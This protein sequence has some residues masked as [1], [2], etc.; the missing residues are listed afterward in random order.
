MKDTLYIAYK[1][2]VFHKLKTSILVACI[3]IILF[4]PIA[5]N[6]LLKESEKQFLS[7]A[8][9][10]PLLLGAKGSSLDLC[11]NSLYFDDEIPEFITLKA[12]EEVDQTGFANAI[13][14]YTRF[15]ARDFPVIG[16]TLDYFS[17]REL[18]L[19]N[20]R[21]FAMLGECVIGSKVAEE[22]G[23]SVGQHL[24][25]AS[26]S[27]FDL[28]G[29]YPLKMKIVGVLTPSYSPDDL[30]VFV[31]LKTC[32][33][34]Q[35]L[36]HGHQD[37]SKL[38]DPTLVYKQ[39]DSVVSATAKLI[40]YNEINEDNI[41]SFHFHGSLDAYPIT[42]LVIFPE[43]A[44]SG[45]LLQGRYVAD[46]SGFQLIKPTL[47][48]DGLLQNIFKISKVI[49]GVIIIVS[50]ATI[51]AMFLIFSLS[52]RLRAKEVETTFKLGCQKGTM[53][54]F[55]LA[56]VVI[57]SGLSIFVC[58]ILYSVFNLYQNDLIRLLYF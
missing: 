22:L 37:V 48:I 23:L 13:P 33:I 4:L 47:V 39:N 14:L 53:L 8:E 44:K 5:L 30:G 10:T 7:R 56:E 43:S 31:D 17:H 58:A 29:V 41:E 52:F 51:L 25:T 35:G 20:G 34:I 6:S 11:M 28:A 21:N 12:K 54:K 46:Q 2:I 16:T 49:D 19:Q 38:S 9:A 15:K 3:T 57:I 18:S 32:W 26:E 40:Q 50:L 42:A 55:L 36:G 27:F 1:Y 45:A 24:V